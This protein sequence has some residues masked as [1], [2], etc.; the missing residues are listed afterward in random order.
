MT[1]KLGDLTIREI[2][3]EC[4]NA[5][6]CHKCKLRFANI[7]CT[8]DYELIEEEKLEEEIELWN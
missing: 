5:S 3:K 7:P 1:K 6:S 8:M 2:A 4:K